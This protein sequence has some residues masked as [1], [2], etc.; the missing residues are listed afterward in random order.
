MKR[1]L[2]VLI[3]LVMICLSAGT[4]QAQEW[5]KEDY[6]YSLEMI[7]YGKWALA[8]YTLDRI[9]DNAVASEL[10]LKASVWAALI[11]AGMVDTYLLLHVQLQEAANKAVLDHKALYSEKA[12]NALT[13]AASIQRAWAPNVINSFAGLGGR[14]V[15]LSFPAGYSLPEWGDRD[16]IE[17]CLQAG[18]YPGDAAISD[19]SN[20]LEAVTIPI[21]LQTFSGLE[22]LA[23]DIYRGLGTDK[24][25]IDMARFYLI[26]GKRCTSEYDFLAQACYETVLKLTENDPTSPIRHEAKKLLE[27]LMTK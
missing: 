19:Y 15:E 1:T 14:Y 7:G 5:L 21:T 16:Y 9:Q 13:R 25:V 22:H 18:R 10:G 23:A 27:A 6:R 20:F 24:L 11:R 3:C 2:C 12:D 26:S 8:L 17:L 4:A